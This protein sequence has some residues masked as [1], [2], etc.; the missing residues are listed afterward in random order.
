MGRLE[1]A[2]AACQF[3]P[4]EEPDDL[5]PMSWDE[6]RS[7]NRRGFTLGAHGLTHAILTRETRERALAEIEQSLSKVTVEVGAPCTTFAF[8]NG[9]YNTELVQHALRCGASTIMT[10]EPA[11]ADTASALG[12]L[13]RIQLFGG[14]SQARIESKI[15]M[16]AFNGLLPNPNGSG[17]GRRF[18]HSEGRTPSPGTSVPEWGY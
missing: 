12:C 8:P 16:A 18:I 15:A 1:E 9:N 17:R 3:K 10:T 6:A 7:L 11:W 14:S 13:P 4:G 5:R 2:C